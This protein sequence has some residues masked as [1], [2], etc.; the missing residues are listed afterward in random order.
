MQEEY[1]KELEGILEEL[2]N[3]LDI[4]ETEYEAAK[5]SYNAVGDYLSKDNSPLKPYNPEI[6]PQGSFMLG[7][8]IKPVNEGDELDVDLV[9]K[10]E[11]IPSYW[12][13]KILKDNV[14]DWLKSNGRYEAMIKNKGG[15]RRCWTLHYA[16]DTNYHLDILPSTTDMNLK[17]FL[18][19]SLFKKHDFDLS[20][21]DELAIRIT[22]KESSPIYEESTDIN[23]WLKSNPFGYA[24]W[25]FQIAVKHQ[26]SE[27]RLF[28]LNE[29]VNPLKPY[30]KRKMPLQRVV[31]LLKR[32]RDIMF[33][34]K[35]Y[36]CEHK[37]ISIIITTLAAK[38]YDLSQHKSNLLESFI[39]I[40]NNMRDC[41]ERKYNPE[42]GEYEW[43]VENPINTCENFADKWPKEPIK[44]EY[45]F[46]WLESVE[47]YVEKLQ[48]QPKITFLSDSLSKR[49]GDNVVTET[50]NAIGKQKEMAR[51]D[52]KRELGRN[53]MLGTLVGGKTVKNHNFYGNCE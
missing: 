18:S 33:S 52:G 6:L 30:T 42:S 41:I 24:T 20:E 37:P 27:K 15:G 4:S 25:F 32:D 22:D 40:V 31:Q 49:Y 19:E 35:K 23:D 12:T 13:Q 16:D 8:M 14:G 51:I 47:S 26:E 53:G 50:F 29:S 5:R 43:W 17:V 48:T 39:D 9:C 45:F 10:L 2:G 3:K 44:E 36:D 28:A 34:D 21:V 46:E 11:K 7:T 38:S 1:R